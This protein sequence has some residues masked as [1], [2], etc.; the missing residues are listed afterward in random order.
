MRLH[1]DLHRGSPGELPGMA[2]GR[3]P[4]YFEMRRGLGTQLTLTLLSLT[5]ADIAEAH[6]G[7]RYFSRIAD[8]YGVIASYR[9]EQSAGFAP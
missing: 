2:A 4:R 7:G 9:I 1:M 5:I 3:G 8:L 6:A